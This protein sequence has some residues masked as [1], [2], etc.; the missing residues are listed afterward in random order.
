MYEFTINF[1]YSSNVEMGALNGESDSVSQ[2]NNFN[3]FTTP[4]LRAVLPLCRW[5]PR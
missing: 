1:Y 5:L 2:E 4:R 3:F